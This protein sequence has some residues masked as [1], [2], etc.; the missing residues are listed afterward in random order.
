MG[1]DMFVQ[2]F[3]QG[4]A[5]PMAADAFLAVFAPRVNRRAPQHSHWHISAEDGGTADVYAALT[6]DTLDSLTI[7][8]FS[9]G[10]VLDMLV[11]FIGLSDA[12]V[13]PPGSPTLLAHE[14]QRDHL[15]EELRADAVVVQA[16]ADVERV[17]LNC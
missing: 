12:V 4:D 10:V 17:I 2:R 3:V 6:G 16:G 15:P 8:R 9:A 7:S 11:E 14:G 5:A 13:L 1:Y